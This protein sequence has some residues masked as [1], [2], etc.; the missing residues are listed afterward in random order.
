MRP[1][2][3]GDAPKPEYKPYGK[4][5]DD[6]TERLGFYCSYCEQPITHAPEVEHVQPK[7]LEPGL[8]TTWNNFL[9]GC[10]SCNTVKGD[11]PVDLTQ[12]AFPDL[13]NT[14]R[15]L[16]FHQDGR[17]TVAPHLAGPEIQLMKNVISLVKLHR[18]PNAPNRD[19]QPTARDKRVDFRLGAWS[20]AQRQLELYEEFL[21]DPEF[22]EVLA[23]QITEELAPSTGFFS[24]WMTVFA[25]HPA[26]LKRF[27]SAFPGTAE[28]CF[29]CNGQSVSRPGGRF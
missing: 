26:M 21:H 14:F 3:K 24:I 15:A 18:H 23:T 12:V 5:L 1:V 20:R 17:V 27:I 2:T 4:A 25:D 22:S 16:S 10:K 19:D 6:L 7:S 8:E 29:D 11:T 13:E 9:L 28:D